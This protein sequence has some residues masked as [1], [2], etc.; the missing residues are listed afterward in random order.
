[1]KQL[2][3]IFALFCASYMTVNAQT[4]TWTGNADTNW[5]TAANWSLNAVPTA[6]NDV[7]IP[8]GKTVNLNVAGTTKSIVLQGNSTLNINNTLSF[9]NASST[10]A[11]AT[12]NWGGASINGDGTLTN[13]GTLNM[14]GGTKSFGGATVINNAGTINY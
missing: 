6:T 12:V 7:I 4:N 1:M 11:N 9:T 2:L 8:T 13:N 14:V 5:G 3:L 10:A